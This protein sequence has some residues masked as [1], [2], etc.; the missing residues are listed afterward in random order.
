[1]R[2]AFFKIWSLEKRNFVNFI[3]SSNLAS[4]RMGKVSDF[5]LYSMILDPNY[6]TTKIFLHAFE[7]H[8]FELQD[9]NKASLF[10][11]FNIV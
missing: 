7:L 11:R 4:V 2:S 8:F 10:F 9:S 5:S 6:V 3:T 1:M